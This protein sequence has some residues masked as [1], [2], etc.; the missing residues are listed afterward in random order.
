V[1]MPLG[2]DAVAGAHG[3]NVREIVAR[4]NDGGQPPMDAIVSATSLA[5]ASVGLGDRIG[6][7]APAFEADVIAVDGDPVRD[8][9]ALRRVTFVMRGGRVV[10]R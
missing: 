2:S 1:I 6:T 8:I 9:E 4:V 10:E 7:L 3:Q 5:A